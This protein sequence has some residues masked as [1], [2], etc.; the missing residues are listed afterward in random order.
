MTENTGKTEL[1]ADPGHIRED[2][3]MVRQAIRQGWDIPEQLLSALP[4][5]AGAMALD[6][7]ASKAVRLKAMETLLKM[8][9]QN[10]EPE[11]RAPAHTINVGVKIDNAADAGRNLASRVLARIAAGELP[12]AVP[13]VDAGT[14]CGGD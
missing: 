14:D 13:G 11:S 5:V 1:L 10:D 12:D 4:K 8:K 9:A 3:K 2:L 7:G 6:K